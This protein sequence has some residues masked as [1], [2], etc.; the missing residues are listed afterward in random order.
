MMTFDAPNCNLF[1][2]TSSTLT[3]F[4]SITLNNANSAVLFNVTNANCF[5]AADYNAAQKYLLSLIGITGPI[6]ATSLTGF[7]LEV[8]RLYLS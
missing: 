1:S 3:L 4:E 7:G 2:A 8:Y 5:F 6:E